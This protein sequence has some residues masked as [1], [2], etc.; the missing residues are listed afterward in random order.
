M[1]MW[2]KYRSVFQDHLN[3]ICNDIV[4]QFRVGILRYSEQVQEMHDQSNHLP[5][6]SME[7]ESFEADSC[8]FC[9]KEFS[10]NDIPFDIEG[11]LPSS[12]QDELEDNQEYYISLARE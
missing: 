10:E 6:P 12:I 7:G 3:H 9:D 1:R 11:R 4:K 2:S 8:K 5:S